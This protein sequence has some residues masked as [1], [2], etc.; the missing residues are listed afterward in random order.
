MTLN[1]KCAFKTGMGKTASAG[2]IQFAKQVVL[3]RGC[4]AAPRRQA[5]QGLGMGEWA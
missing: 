1:R 4:S 2:W 3:A 5:N